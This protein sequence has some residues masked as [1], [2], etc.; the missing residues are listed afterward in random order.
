MPSTVAIG[1]WHMTAMFSHTSVHTLF[2]TCA[3]GN[4]NFIVF[5]LTLCDRYEHAVSEVL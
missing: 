3:F 1:C 4:C 5:F 2:K